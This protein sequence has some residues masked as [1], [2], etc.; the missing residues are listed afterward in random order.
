M[1]RA[2]GKAQ[3]FGGG[4]PRAKYYI[5]I[6]FVNIF[7]IIFCCALGTGA[8]GRMNSIYVRDPDGNLIEIAYY[9]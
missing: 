4:R 3:H 5:I 7:I 9:D 6:N 2:L 1:A 8:R